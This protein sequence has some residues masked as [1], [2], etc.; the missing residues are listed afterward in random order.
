MGPGENR[1][2]DE[3]FGRTALPPFDDHDDRRLIENCCIKAAK[4]P[5][6]LGHPL[7]KH[8]RAARVPVVVTRRLGALATADRLPCEREASGGS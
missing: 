6:G 8:A 4:Q 2:L 3:C 1:L 7:Q 5:W